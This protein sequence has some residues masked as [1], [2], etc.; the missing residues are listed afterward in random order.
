LK[1][2][3]G[4]LEKEM[5]ATENE[6]DETGEKIEVNFLRNCKM[7]LVSQCGLYVCQID[8]FVI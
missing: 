1:E 6:G 8:M 7:R 2:V 3:T 4:L 5:T